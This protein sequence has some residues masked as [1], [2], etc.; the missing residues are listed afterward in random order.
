MESTNRRPAWQRAV[1]D[2]RQRRCCT[3]DEG[4]ARQ[5]VE[6]ASAH[7]VSLDARRVREDIEDGGCGIPAAADGVDDPWSAV[8]DALDARDE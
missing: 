6:R 4:L 1:L 8:D 2:A 3:G 5:V 7:G